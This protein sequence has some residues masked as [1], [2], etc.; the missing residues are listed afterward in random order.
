MLISAEKPITKEQYCRA[1]VNHGYIDEVDMGIIFDDALLYG[2][3]VYSPV[4]RKRVNKET[5]E[6]EYYVEYTTSTCCD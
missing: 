1:M 5:G 2:Y 6:V 4:G 3:G